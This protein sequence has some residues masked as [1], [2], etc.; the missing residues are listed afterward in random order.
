MRTSCDLV[1]ERT[2]PKALEAIKTF[3]KAEKILSNGI[4]LIR[5]ANG[6]KKDLP[7]VFNEVAF[8]KESLRE[9]FGIEPLVGRA[10]VFEFSSNELKY[11]GPEHSLQG[12]LDET[13]SDTKERKEEPNLLRG[14]EGENGP[15]G[16]EEEEEI[17]VP[18]RK[19]R[20]VPVDVYGDKFYCYK[21]FP[22]KI[23]NSEVQGAFDFSSDHYKTLNLF[24]HLLSLGTE[25]KEGWDV[26]QFGLDYLL[27]EFSRDGVT[28]E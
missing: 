16:E 5:S 14:A 2:L 18:V 8:T 28:T 10:S 1:Y 12:H 9:K 19:R 20:P 6:L 27:S 4:E 7:S 15:E 23:L 22:K 17:E 21:P 24:E 26:D 3:D 13:S 11:L 25:V